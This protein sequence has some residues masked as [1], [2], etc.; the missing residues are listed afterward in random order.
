MVGF[1]EQKTPRPF[2][3]ACDRFIFT[4]LLEPEALSRQADGKKPGKQLE[5]DTRLVNLIRNAVE[6]A[7]DDTG[8]AHLGQVGSNIA[9]QS[10][11]FDARTYGYAKLSQLAAAMP[12]L[13]IEERV[14]GEG[15]A[16]YV[17]N[18]KRA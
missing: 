17:R 10:P 12:L 13:E 14:Q 16:F 6:A 4:E 3:A 8:W 5:A 15:S 11:E 2:V 9:K 18:R 7:S 1:G